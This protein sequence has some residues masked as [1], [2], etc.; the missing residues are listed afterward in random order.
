MSAQKNTDSTLF[1]YYSITR[2]SQKADL[3]AA[4]NFFR[5]M[6]E[7]SLKAGD[8]L[9]AIYAIRMISVGTY[10]DGEVFESEQQA[11]EGLELIGSQSSEAYDQARMGLYTQLG[12]I[13]RNIADYDQA[14][15]IYQKALTFNTSPEEKTRILNNLANVYKSKGAYATSKDYLLQALQLAT[16]RNDSANRALVLDNL[17]EVQ[18]H[19]NEPEAIQSLHKALRIRKQ[20][21]NLK[22][23]YT[24]YM[25]LA[26]YHSGTNPDSTVYYAQQAYNVSDSMNNA[27]YK[28]DALAILIK[29]NPDARVNEYIRLSDSISAALQNEENKYAYRK[30]NTAEAEKRA[31]IARIESES[32]RNM[33]LLYQWIGILVIVIALLLFLVFRLRHKRDRAREVY[34]TETRISKKVHDE[35]ANDVYHL[36]TQLQQQQ[37][38]SDTTLDSLEV[39]YQ[40][41]RDISR[42]ISAI[43]LDE[44]FG[45]EL[46]DLLESYRT[47][48]VN[49]IS[50]NLSAVNWDQY[51][52]EK[53]LTVYRV[54][55]ELMTNMKKH[56]E[57][58]LVAVQFAQ[59]GKKLTVTY[60]DNG[61]GSTL[62]AGNG[63][64]NTENRMENIN[65]SISFET[66]PGNGFKA[67]LE[68]K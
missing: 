30:W 61:K 15:E 51:S 5:R 36:M 23:R 28:K 34:N 39:L 68:M 43:S 6:K 14:V 17:G 13:Y 33:K 37:E 22:S 54:L 21:S 1:Y 49:I 66:S 20:L 62:E 2:P 27:P 4:I 12:M 29:N 55:Q 64:R 19:L 44:D 7:S 31:E 60:F 63:L 48:R 26:E 8:T 57:A 52:R 41:T 65:G 24:S 16:T 25:S 59:Q 46:K 10:T 35:V 42:E 18:Q 3:P 38:A 56:S 50:R 32:E 45:S 67:T 47:A 9:N 11:V 53:K 40:K 58:G